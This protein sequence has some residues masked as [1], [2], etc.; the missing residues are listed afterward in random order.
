MLKTIYPKAYSLL[1]VTYLRL[2]GTRDLRALWSPPLFPK[3]FFNRNDTKSAYF[4][5]KKVKFAKFR[6]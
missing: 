3:D 2:V 1:H 6:P 5:D 4:K